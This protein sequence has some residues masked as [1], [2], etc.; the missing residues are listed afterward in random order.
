LEV[1]FDDHLATIAE[2]FGGLSDE[3]LADLSKQAWARA[4]AADGEVFDE[5]ASCDAYDI[6]LGCGQ[7]MDW[8]ADDRHQQL[9][10]QSDLARDRDRT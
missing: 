7:Q 2:R 6:A 8:R 4:D 1:E 3:A 9:D 10:R 5:V